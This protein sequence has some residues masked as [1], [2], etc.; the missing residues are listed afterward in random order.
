[1]VPSILLFLLFVNDVFLVGRR[2]S[3][4]LRGVL[5]PVILG[6]SRMFAVVSEV[7]LIL[8]VVGLLTPPVVVDKHHIS[9]VNSPLRLRCRSGLL[10]LL[11]SWRGEVG[12]QPAPGYL[13]HQSLGGRDGDPVTVVYWNVEK[14]ATTGLI[15]VLQCPSLKLDKIVRFVGTRDRQLI[16]EV[17][18]CSL[19]VPSGAQ[20]LGFV[21]RNVSLSP[22]IFNMKSDLLKN[23]L[24]P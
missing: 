1:M 23:I 18:R 17:N 3:D 7:G 13:L 10:H 22:G 15:A 9:L 21:S 8:P 19:V 24:R 4:G 2:V 12:G 11:L 14:P 16:V 5:P 6:S 20:T